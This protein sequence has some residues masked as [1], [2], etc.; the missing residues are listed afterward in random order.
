MKHSPL[1]G[2][3]LRQNKMCGGEVETKMVVEKVAAATDEEK[4]NGTN[5][6]LSLYQGTKGIFVFVFIFLET[7]RKRNKN[8]RI[9]FFF[10]QT[11]FENTF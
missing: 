2:F 10:E 7:N 4:K 5:I 9:I 3:K 11:F 1:Y 8:I 6:L